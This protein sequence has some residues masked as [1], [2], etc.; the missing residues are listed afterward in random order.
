M[1]ANPE[2]EECGLLLSTCT[3]TGLGP[4]CEFCTHNH[5]HKKCD[6][7][8]E[9]AQKQWGWYESNIIKLLRVIGATEGQC[10]GCG[11]DIWWVTHANGK[12]APYTKQGLN[13]FADCPKA[14]EFK[15]S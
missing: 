2:C 13:H 3:A 10:R 9:Q 7:A 11:I 5:P 12:K 6:Q 4:C 15:R 8:T 1:S 14:K